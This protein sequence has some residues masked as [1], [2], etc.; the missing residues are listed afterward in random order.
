MKIIDEIESD[1]KGIREVQYKIPSYDRV[2]NITGYKDKIFVKTIYDPKVF[3]DQ[4]ILDLGKQAASN[5]YKAAI[6]SRQ[7]EYTAIAGGIKF[8]IYLDLRTGVIENFHP[9]ANL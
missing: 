7:R 3:T 8:Q 4:Q 6:K 9:V 5:G 1:V 2:G